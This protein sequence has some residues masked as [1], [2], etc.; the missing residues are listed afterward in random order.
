MTTYPVITVGTGGDY[1]SLAA[2]LASLPLNWTTADIQPE[3]QV[4]DLLVENVTVSGFTADATRY[5]HITA[6]P[7]CSFMDHPDVRT[8]PLHYN[9]SLGAA[10]RGASDYNRTISCNVPY[11]RFSRL[12]VLGLSNGEAIN[13]DG[14][15][16][17]YQNLILAGGYRS[18]IFGGSGGT[19]YT[20]N[21]VTIAA[22]TY[23]YPY[24]LYNATGGGT[25]YITNCTF[26]RPASFGAYAY[27]IYSEY[28]GSGNIVKNTAAFGFAGFASHSLGTTANNATDVSSGAG[29][30]ALHSLTFA[31]QFETVTGAMSA[32]DFRLKTGSDLINAGASGGTSTDITGYTRGTPDIG[33]FEYDEAPPIADIESSDLLLGSLLLGSPEAGVVFPLEGSSLTL[34]SLT[35]GSPEAQLV[36]PLEGSTLT[37]GSLTLGA[38]EAHLIIH[39]E[40]TSLTLGT[41]TLGTPTAVSVFALEASS[42]TLGS[43]RLGTPSPYTNSDLVAVDL[44]LGALQIGVATATSPLSEPISATAAL[45]GENGSAT[46]TAIIGIDV[47]R[48]QHPAGDRIKDVGVPLR[49]ASVLPAPR[50]LRMPEL[51]EQRPARIAEIR[52]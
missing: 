31:D 18:L 15:S 26:I 48:L 49:E 22:V 47:Q 36:V 12:Q 21:V 11:T 52:L 41:L 32:L 37:L 3:L 7:G 38:P 35:L 13:N 5:L 6:A 19:T 39:G 40:S 30:G 4:L 51:P 23:Y 46:S 16:G 9:E 20:E 24:G 2:A 17:R 34:G 29:T 1:T 14:H 10:I 8:N 50:A 25:H 33:A 43:L 42:L 28:S 27:G 45:V 44:A